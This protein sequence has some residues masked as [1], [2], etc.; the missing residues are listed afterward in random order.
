M[1]GDFRLDFWM[2]TGL[3]TAYSILLV[4][5]FGGMGRAASREVTLIPVEMVHKK[6][7]RYCSSARALL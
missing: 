4:D 5:D 2:L 3:L 7:A 1:P 6:P